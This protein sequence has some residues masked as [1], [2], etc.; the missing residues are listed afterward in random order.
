[1]ADIYRNGRFE[2][3]TWR[4]LGADE[5]PAAGDTVLVPADRFLAD[6]AGFAAS[7]ARLGVVIAPADKLEDLAPHLQIFEVAAVVFP[8]FND[9]RGF[10]HARRL[11]DKYGF[12]GE[13]RA[14]GE[15]LLDQIPLMSRVGISAFVI[16]NEPTR[17]ELLAGNVP[18]VP[19]F[20]QPASDAP[21]ALAGRRW[22]QRG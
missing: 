2:A 7:P 6:P 17:R 18:V 21:D 16:E 8:K 11:A 19:Y 20:Y 12:K 9:G 10:S 1:M 22:L 5:T 13:I 4:V 3:D 14:L 15:V